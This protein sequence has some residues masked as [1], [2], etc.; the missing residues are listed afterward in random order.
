MS[1]TVAAAAIAQDQQ[2]GFTILINYL[3]PKADLADGASCFHLF[4][5]WIYWPSIANYVGNLTAESGISN[6]LGSL[7]IHLARF[8]L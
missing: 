4:T 8:Y 1:R 5:G 6:K 2:R 3:Y 7:F